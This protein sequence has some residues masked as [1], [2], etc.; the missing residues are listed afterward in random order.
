MCC[1]NVGNVDFCLHLLQKLLF[2]DDE[3]N[4]S[5]CGDTSAA[6]AAAVLSD[7]RSEEDDQDVDEEFDS[8]FIDDDHNK[9]EP[10]TNMTQQYLQ[11]VKY[12][13]C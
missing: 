6:M 13:S 8:S 9:S 10:S 11:S 1:F 2:I 12:V 7:S 5:Y 3:A 4:V